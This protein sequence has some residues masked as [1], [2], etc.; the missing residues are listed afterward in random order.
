MRHAWLCRWVNCEFFSHLCSSSLFFFLFFLP[1]SFLLYIYIYINREISHVLPFGEIRVGL[2]QPL[3]H[4]GYL[5]QDALEKAFDG[6]LRGDNFE[7]ATRQFKRNDF[8]FAPVELPCA[9]AFLYSNINFKWNRGSSQ[10]R[11]WCLTYGYV[12]HIYIH[13]HPGIHR[14]TRLVDGRYIR[15]IHCTHMIGG[16][17]WWFTT[18]MLPGRFP[19]GLNTSRPTTK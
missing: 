14:K 6:R 17:G 5:T 10:N 18:G 7:S 15:Y 11:S 13:N 12:M 1:N 4:F 8:A 9:V 2:T 16:W 19:I 3:V